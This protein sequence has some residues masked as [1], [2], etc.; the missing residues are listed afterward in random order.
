MALRGIRLT[1]TGSLDFLPFTTNIPCMQDK[2][3]NGN[4]AENFMNNPGRKNPFC[5]LT[6]KGSGVVIMK[7]FLK[8]PQFSAGRRYAAEWWDNR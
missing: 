5:Q 3:M 7:T 6:D 2:T 1:A 4:A 8:F